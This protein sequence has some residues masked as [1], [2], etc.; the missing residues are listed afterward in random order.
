MIF[1]DKK[2]VKEIIESFGTIEVKHRDDPVWIDSLSTN[3]DGKIQVKDLN[4]NKYLIVDIA[5]LK[6]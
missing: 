4:T 2:R 5:D 1:L 3:K 6:E